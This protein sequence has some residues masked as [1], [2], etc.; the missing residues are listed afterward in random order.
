MSLRRKHCG[1]YAVLVSFLGIMCCSQLVVG[2]PSFP[3]LYSS[4][5]PFL[6]FSLTPV[7]HPPA[8]NPPALT[9]KHPRVQ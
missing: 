7:H 4:S 1:L 9:T 3:S 6:I 8:V 5:L 2:P